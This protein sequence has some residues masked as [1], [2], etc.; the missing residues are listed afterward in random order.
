M[1][2]YIEEQKWIKD[3]C[4]NKCSPKHTQT[5]NLKHAVYHA[6][7]STVWRLYDSQWDISRC[8][9]TEN[10]RDIY[11][12]DQFFYFDL[13]GHNE[14]TS[15]RARKIYKA[16]LPKYVICGHSDQLKAGQTPEE[17]C[18]QTIG[19]KYV[20]EP[21]SSIKPRANLDRFQEPNKDIFMPL[22]FWVICHVILSRGYLSSTDEYT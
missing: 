8:H 4:I 14:T 6:G 5:G 22:I 19:Y 21:A 16:D 18:I 2:G 17:S 9:T 11:I 3:G 12:Q 13:H 7:R 10:L 1:K 20:N 15:K